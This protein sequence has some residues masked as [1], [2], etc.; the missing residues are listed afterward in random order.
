M[1][2]RSARCLVATFASLAIVN[3]ACGDGEQEPSA[4]SS[5]TVAV[6]STPLPVETAL[7]SPTPEA[8][9]TPSPTAAEAPSAPVLEVSSGK[10][11]QSEGTRE[12]TLAAGATLALDARE[13]A[14]ELGATIVSCI[15]TSFYLSWQAR[16][17][18]PP[19]GVDL[20]FYEMLRGARILIA[21]GAS[22][23]FTRGACLAFEI[24]NNSAVD[25]EV[26]LRY[27]FDG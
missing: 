10:T 5:P 4:S 13:F 24:V 11:L 26:E 16:D 18:F 9:R 3:T 7:R 2:G 21:E 17:P 19:S 25:V 12:I 14:T 20:E 1:I 8:T 15:D 23:Q 6:S 27:G 22:G